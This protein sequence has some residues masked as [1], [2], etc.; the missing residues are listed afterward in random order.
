MYICTKAGRR[1]LAQLPVTIT[2]P[3]TSVPAVW[4]EHQDRGRLVW[5]GRGEGDLSMVHSALELILALQYK[6]PFLHAG[7]RQVDVG[8]IK[9]G[10]SHPA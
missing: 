5:V 6:V 4:G 7:E 3:Q 10:G 1:T 9:A 2:N 8:L